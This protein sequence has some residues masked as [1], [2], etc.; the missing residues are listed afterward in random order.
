MTE[1]EPLKYPEVLYHYCSPQAFLDI[2]RS[3]TIRLSSVFFMNDNKEYYW[4]QEQALKYI[5][6]HKHE[7]PQFYEKVERALRTPAINQYCA[8]FS[9]ERDLLSQWRAYADDGRGFAIGFNPKHFLQIKNMPSATTIEGSPL[10]PV[11]YDIAAQQEIIKKQ[12]RLVKLPEEA[13]QTDKDVA[14]NMSVFASQWNIWWYGG[15][16]KNPAFAEEK[17]WRFGSPNLDHA[18]G[19]KLAFRERNGWIVPFHEFKF[20]MEASEPPILKIGFG[21]SNNLPEAKFSVFHLLNESGYN[22][23]AI[24]FY[25]SAAS[26]RSLGQR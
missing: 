3:K 21:P 12:F 20:D 9:E 7:E 23:S 4:F 15:M 8:S 5:E 6:E 1:T 10:R 13:D 11:I 22:L 2:V 26:Y 19:G 24:K 25:N 14:F 16:C 17:E 18:W